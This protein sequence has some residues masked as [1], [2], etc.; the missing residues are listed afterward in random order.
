MNIL[1][2]EER[3]A[4]I[5]P[6]HQADHAAH[7][8]LDVSIDEYQA[9]EAAVLKKLSAGVSVEPVAAM[10]EGTKLSRGAPDAGDV[11]F[12]WVPLYT[13]AAIAAARVQALEEAAKRVSV[14]EA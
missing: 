10:L 7:M 12:G 6:L 9:I 14:E 4:A 11:A 2:D 1:T 13:A 8:A 3:F 5:R